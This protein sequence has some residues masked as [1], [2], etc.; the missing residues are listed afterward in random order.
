MV[1]YRWPLGKP[2]VE[3]IKGYPELWE[4]RSDLKRRRIARILFTVKGSS[5]ALLHSFIKKRQK[6]P[7]N[8]LVEADR[9]KKL[10]QQGEK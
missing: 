8:I 4:V 9:R 1:Q 7:R 3:K 10:W 5:M 6:T 2:L